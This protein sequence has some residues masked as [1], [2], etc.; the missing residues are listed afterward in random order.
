MAFQFDWGEPLGKLKQQ[1]F[2]IESISMV[3]QHLVYAG[4]RLRDDFILADYGIPNGAIMFLTL[5]LRGGG[6]EEK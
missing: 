3:E 2:R 5:P 1:I 4:N 6:D